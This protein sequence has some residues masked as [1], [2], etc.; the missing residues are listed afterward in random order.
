MPK[1]IAENDVTIT[2]D[3][4][5]QCNFSGAEFEFALTSAGVFEI[6]AEHEIYL[7]SYPN[8]LPAPLR[9]IRVLP[10][11]PSPEHTIVGGPGLAHFPW[12]IPGRDQG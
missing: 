1:G 6:H 4:G 7:L 12:I 3:C 11:M 8:D 10:G 9:N 2:D 5:T